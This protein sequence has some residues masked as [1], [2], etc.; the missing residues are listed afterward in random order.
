MAMYLVV[1]EHVW[2]GM[3][4]SGGIDLIAY[5]LKEMLYKSNRMHSLMDQAKGVLHTIGHTV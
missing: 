4:A 1:I 2:Y 5:R 3:R